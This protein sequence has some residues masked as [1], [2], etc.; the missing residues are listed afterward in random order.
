MNDENENRNLSGVN[1]E[2]MKELLGSMNEDNDDAIERLG[3]KM[4]EKLEKNLGKNAD[5][6]PIDDAF[7]RRA[8]QS[9]YD[10]VKTIM[11]TVKKA[12]L[13]PLMF[14]FPGFE[15]RETKKLSADI[16]RQGLGVITD[17]AIIAEAVRK[18]I[19]V[20]NG[21]LFVVLV[22]EAWMYEGKF[23]KADLE[24]LRRGEIKPSDLPKDQHKECV[25][26]NGIGPGVQL[27]MA[28]EI[29]RAPDGVVT[30]SKGEIVSSN[31]EGAEIGGNFAVTSK[32]KPPKDEE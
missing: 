27:M 30:L 4:I 3:R 9:V 7:M 23:P 12:E 15:D 19:D 14:I 1:E 10:G 6:V 16:V 29:K 17:K 22:D 31:D 20:V 5:K 8:M 18:G 21:R 28:N 24:K 2:Y 13:P 32:P 11:E 26:L 25:L